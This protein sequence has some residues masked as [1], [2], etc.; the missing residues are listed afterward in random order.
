VKYIQL[1]RRFILTANEEIKNKWL[2]EIL[3]DGVN[4]DVLYVMSSIVLI[5]FYISVDETSLNSWSVQQ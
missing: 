2:D 3:E 1:T 4:T 5:S